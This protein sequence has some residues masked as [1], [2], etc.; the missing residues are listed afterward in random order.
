M[1]TLGQLN[2]LSGI[3]HGFFTRDGGVSDGLY[4]SK[5]CGFG[6]D[7]ARENVARNR[8]RCMAEL[9]ARAPALVTVHQTHSA[10]AVAATVPWEPDGAPRADALVTDRPGIALGILTA[11]CAPVLL[12]D[13]R[14]G[15]IGA[16]HAGWRGALDGVIEATVA[17]MQALGAEPG[18]LVCGIGPRIGRRSYE[19]GPEF[20]DRFLA[21]DPENDFFFSPAPRDGRLLFDLV[22]YVARRLVALGV[23]EVVLAP[24]DTFVE[25]QRFFSYRRAC[26][27]GEP[28]YG[29]CLSAIVIDR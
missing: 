25:E 9:A 26:L 20:R 5:N 3:R 15:V 10:T 29:R 22:T 27:R 14:G 23:A 7:D 18:R 19:V 4:A 11:D 16:A 13:P 8:A 1:I 28:D 6:S 2:D 12:V 24:N 17:A 21:A